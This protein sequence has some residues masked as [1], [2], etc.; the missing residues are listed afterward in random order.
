MTIVRDIAKELLA[1][2]VA[3]SALTVMILGLVVIVAV[4]ISIGHVAPLIS[5]GSLL[6]G[7][8]TIMLGSAARA[9]RWRGASCRRDR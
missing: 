8:V 5:G 3:D 2:F 6:L 4:L 1:M 9:A 7:S